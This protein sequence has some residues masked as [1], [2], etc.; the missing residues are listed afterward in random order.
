[1]ALIAQS[2][3]FWAQKPVFWPEI[4][5]LWTASKKIV[6]IMTGH[7]KNN[8]FVS[9]ALQGGH[10]EAVQVLLGPKLAAKS[11]FYASPI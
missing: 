10:R 8:L 3:P 11:D 4:N 7:L 5:F 6:T 2:G 1:M 9:T